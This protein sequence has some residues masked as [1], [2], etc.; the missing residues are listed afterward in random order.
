[1]SGDSAGREEG[2]VMDL[3][4]RERVL[5]D[6]YLMDSVFNYLDTPSLTTVRRVSR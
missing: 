2:G 4:A 1:M 6:R 5:G 3:T